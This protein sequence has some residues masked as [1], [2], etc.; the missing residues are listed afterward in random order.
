MIYFDTSATTLQKP[1][2]VAQAAAWAVENLGNAGRSAYQGAGLAARA[3]YSARRAVAALCGVEDPLRVAFTSG[4]TEGLNLL[5]GGLVKPDDHVI[6]TVLEHNS[7]LRPLYQTGCTLSFVDCDDA[8]GLDLDGLPGLLRENTRF[9]VCTHGS[10]VLG[11]RTDAGRIY[12]FCR[13]NGLV[14]ILDASQTMG[15]TLVDGDGADF[16]CFTGHKGLMGPQGTGG[17]IAAEDAPAHIFKTGG[18]GADS[19]ARHQPAR[20]PDMLEAGTA[21]AQGLYA[22]EKG[23]AFILGLGIEAV[24]ARLHDLT[25]RFL[26][27]AA[28]I[29][30]LTLYGGRSAENHLPVVAL[31]LAGAVSE[32]VSLQLWEE[33][34]IATRPGSHCAPLV[35]RRFGTEATGM[36]RF[37]FG[38]YNTADE[39]D[40]ALAALAELA[41]RM[42][43]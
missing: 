22:L 43:G 34:G 7:V 18:T 19:F 31:N 5:I 4:A 20:M 8:G 35:H 12:D 17:V 37:S 6:T 41:A 38:W 2:A 28:A 26:S 21:N 3:V 27:G 23:L 25:Q 30:G 1:P 29:P 24:E 36:V 10:N 11:S 32:D 40:T 14:F 16:I 39:I 13:E 15:E 42:G 33:Y 9:V